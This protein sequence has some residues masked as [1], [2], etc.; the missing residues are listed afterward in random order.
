[1]YWWS[2]I[3]VPQMPDTRVVVPAS[4]A[5]RFGYTAGLEISPVP[6]TAGQD[7]S[8]ATTIQRTVD[9]FFR[10]P[11]GQRPWIAALDGQGKGLV[12]VSTSRLKGRKLFMWGMGTGGQNWQTFLSE[13]GHAY[14]EIQAGL[15]TTQLER[16][17]MPAGASGANWGPFA[18]PFAL[19]QEIPARKVGK[20]IGHFFGAIEIDGFIDK[21]E[22]KRQID[23]W[24][25]VFRST[26][27]APGTNGPLIPGDPEREAEAIRSKE[28]I[29]LLSAVVDDLLD[30]SK[31]TGIPFQSK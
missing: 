21:N 10:L 14:L 27:P 4:S 6:Y 9:Y 17:P 25:R 20:G 3:A 13:P 28:G 15:A 26:K 2:N 29:P 11:E 19:R 5:Y 18:P 1:M 16:L 22:F 31:K 24:I 30:I 23:D 8:Y 12:Q 7:I